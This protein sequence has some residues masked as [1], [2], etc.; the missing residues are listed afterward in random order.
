L[1]SFENIINGSETG[2]GA[3][4]RVGAGEI[5]NVENKEEYSEIEI[6]QLSE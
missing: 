3:K 1:I 6:L 4:A 2:Q 5:V